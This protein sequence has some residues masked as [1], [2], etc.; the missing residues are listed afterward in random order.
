MNISHLLRQHREKKSYP[1]F[2]IRRLSFFIL[3]S[4]FS[5]P[6]S[7]FLLSAQIV[8]SLED[9]IRM[10]QEQSVEAK[11]AKNTYII[12]SYDYKLYR[13]SLLPTLNLTG[14]LPAFNRTISTITMP[15]GSESFVSQS[16]GNYSGT[17][18]INQP[19]PFTGG[20]LYVSTGLQRL[21][22]YQDSTTTSYLANLINIGINQSILA[23]NPYKW[24]KKIE[25]LQY[26]KAEREY[27]EQ[28]EKTALS[29]FCS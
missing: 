13:K 25:P 22:I 3:L 12:A 15:D 7:A 11:Q 1:G 23:Y 21:D 29:Y 24:Q 26:Q 17:L 27:I 14:S 10:A 5:V 19:I 28:L 4:A 18:S 8:L 20:H 6:H 16:V 9:C 2:L